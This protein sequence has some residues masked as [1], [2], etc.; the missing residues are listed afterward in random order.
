MDE[1]NS[2]IRSL[3]IFV[4]MGAAAALVA[5]VAIMFG[6]G[7]SGSAAPAQIQKASAVV[8]A[9]AYRNTVSVT[10]TATPTAGNLLIAVVG[11][12]DTTTSINLPTDGTGTWSTAGSTYPGSPGGAIFYKIANGSETTVTVTTTGGTNNGSYGLG[13]QVYEYSGMA[14][15]SPL[16]AVATGNFCTSSCTAALTS[17]PVTTTLAGDLLIAGGTLTAVP[18]SPGA[19]PLPLSS[20]SL[21]SRPAPLTCAPSAARPS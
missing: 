2:A 7:G 14:P 6:G 15:S 10:L 5:I 17:N 16:D 8:G 18:P 11:E 12:S 3:F 19:A 1:K 9:D 13:L 4:G 20:S 21:T